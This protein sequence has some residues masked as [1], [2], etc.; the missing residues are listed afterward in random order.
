MKAV[1]TLDKYISKQLLEVFLMGIVIFTSIVFASDT[2]TSLIKQISMYGIPFNIAIL[3]VV[4]KLPSIL[5][6]SI[7]MGVL[8]SIVMTINKLSLNSEITVVRSC[9]IGLSRIAKPAF[10][11]AISGMFV[12][13]FINE[14]IAPFANAQAKKL[15]IWAIQQQN[16]P[17]GKVN[18]TIKQTGEHNVLKKLLYVEKSEK[19]SLNNLTVLDVS[20]KNT[21]QIVQANKGSANAEAWEFKNGVIYTINDTGKK[22]L[23]ST[24]FDNLTLYNTTSGLKDKL[25]KESAE[26]MSFFQLLRYIKKHPNLE[27]QYLNE[28]KVSLYDKLALPTMSVVFALL[29]VPLAMTPPRAR[30]NRGFLFSIL[31]IFLYYLVRALCLSLG[32]TGTL[33]A[34]I[35]A[36]LPNIVLFSAGAYMYHKKAFKIS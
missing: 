5:V 12:C 21:I 3:I 19:K 17:D 7:P 14:F 18:F 9:A 30:F 2:F 20:K 23:N 1:K 15:T 25:L 8:F 28:L 32:E 22:I 11:F 13:F 29:G 34:I 4:L 31:L 6:L 27:K 33:P 24:V 16:V 26:E 10:A 35:A 36:W